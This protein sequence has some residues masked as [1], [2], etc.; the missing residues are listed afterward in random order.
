MGHVDT[1]VLLNKKVLVGHWVQFVEVVVHYRQEGEHASQICRGFEK[2]PDE[3]DDKH[4]VPTKVPVIH[5]LHWISLKHSRQGYLQLVQKGPYAYVYCG[6][7][8][9][10]F[11]S[12]V[13]SLKLAVQLKQ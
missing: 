8:A 9:R 2:Y 6:Q 1:H 5:V 12:T 3:Q 11:I 7:L 4:W 13:Y 10:H